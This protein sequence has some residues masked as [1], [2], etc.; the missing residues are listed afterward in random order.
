MKKALIDQIMLG[1]L[2]FI[3]LIILGATV[4]D[5]MEAR[6]KYYKLKKITDNAVLSMAKYYV[7]VEEDTDNAEDIAK[8]MLEETSLGLEIKDNIQFDWDFSTEPATVTAFI[9]N[10]QHETF[11]FK[12]FDLDNFEISATSI[13]NIMPPE[14]LTFSENLLPFGINGCEESHLIPSKDS[15][16][17]LLFDLKGERG[18]S[19]DNYSEFYGVGMGDECNANGNSKWAHFKNNVH[20]EFYVENGFLNTEEEKYDVNTD[21]NICIPSVK[22]LSMEQDNDPKQISQAFKNLENEDDLVGVQ[23]DL[24]MF[25]CDSKADDLVIKKFIR[26]EFLSSPY[27]TYKD[28]KNDYDQFQ[29]FVKIIGSTLPSKVILKE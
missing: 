19:Y 21:S 4:S 7:N 26:V 10:Y 6:D 22:T 29:F 16:L 13:A 24:V 5:N 2:L 28:V 20:K 18:Y 23:A 17:N 12:L 25:D 3:V 14:E 1:L 8:E 9:N 11:W 15:E 27:S